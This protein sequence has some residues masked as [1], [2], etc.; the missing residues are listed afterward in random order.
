MLSNIF[1]TQIRLKSRHQ[2]PFWAIMMCLGGWYVFS[3]IT[4]RGGGGVLAL[5][6]GGG[7]RPACS[8]PDHVAI[9]L[10]AKKDT[11]SQF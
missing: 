3:N 1:A 2:L 5:E 10:M 4:S 9:R 11:L 6:M 7:V 8:K